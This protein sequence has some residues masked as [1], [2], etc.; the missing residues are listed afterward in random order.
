MTGEITVNGE[1]YNSAMPAQRLSDEDVAA[2]LNY[3]YSNWGN[4]GTT[5]TPEKVKDTK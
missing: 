1:T 3:V 5:I 4:N 2:V